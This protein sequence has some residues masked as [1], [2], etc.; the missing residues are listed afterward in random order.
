MCSLAMGGILQEEEDAYGREILAHFMGEYSY[1]VVE[2]D[3]GYFYCSGGPYSYFLEYEEWPEHQ[4]AGLEYASGRVLD[5][6]CGAG[7]V[8][9]HLQ[10]LGFSVLSI[11]NSPLS[12]EVCRM[13]GLRK[14]KLMPFDSIGPQLGTFQTIVLYGNNFGLFESADRARELLGRFHDISSPGATILAESNDYTDTDEEEHLAYRQWNQERGRMPGQ[15]RL[16]VRFRKYVTPWF[17]YLT[18]T[19]EEMQ[20]IVEPAG[21]HLDRIIQEEDNNMYV[22][23]LKRKE[24][25]ENYSSK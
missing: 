2:R 9:L 22:G 20:E 8:G 14:V 19:P 15:F 24:G 6:G 5:V 17:D 25:V 10:D 7:R 23:V 16:R 12:I 3:D 4:K 1:E 21:W 11:D 18:V 13:R